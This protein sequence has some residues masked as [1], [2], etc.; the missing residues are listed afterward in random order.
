MNRT[1][2][3]PFSP[4]L[5]VCRPPTSL[6]AHPGPASV[7]SNRDSHPPFSFSCSLSPFALSLSPSLSLSRSHC[8]DHRSPRLA[9]P[10]RAA[11]ACTVH[12]A[13]SPIA[14][15]L[16]P[17]LLSVSLR[18]LSRSLA[19]TA[20]TRPI[21]HLVLAPGYLDYDSDD[22]RGCRPEEYVRRYA[23]M[24]LAGHPCAPV[25][26]FLITRR[27]ATYMRTH[28]ER[29]RLPPPPPP[30]PPPPSPPPPAVNTRPSV[31]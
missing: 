20:R 25:R 11:T 14:T 31:P 22:Y 23:H 7:Q 28:T 21:A 29:E 9:M 6:H 30:P 15:P 13:C 1:V 3:R 8:L 12:G 17:F 26:T 18:T 27:Q 24:R 5:S 4:S 10:V 2:L 19:L 16:S